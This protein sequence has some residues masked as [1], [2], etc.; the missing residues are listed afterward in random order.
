MEPK[1]IFIDTSGWIELLLAGELHH[2][3]ISSYFLSEV[4]AGSKLFTCD[5]VLDESWTR[6]ITAQSV[7]AAKTLRAKVKEAEAS[8]K[9]LIIWTDETVFERSWS[10]FLKYADH[11]LS[12]TDAVIATMIRDVKIDEVLTLDRGFQ[13]I[14]LTVRPIL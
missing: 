12:F 5:Y 9:L 14:G 4:K 10:T 11:R 13:N 3:A 2:Q 1:R 7:R 8:G 6:L